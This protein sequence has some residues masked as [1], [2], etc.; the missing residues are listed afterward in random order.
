MR[1]Y[2]I[3]HSGLPNASFSYVP[4][5]RLHCAFLQYVI[6]YF[7]TLGTL[8]AVSWFL[9]LLLA[10]Q[11]HSDVLAIFVSGLFVAAC[12]KFFLFGSDV[13]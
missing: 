7:L 1:H 9:Y 12:S 6:Q 13:R 10:Q 3:E 8:G 11:F 2:S 4:I 5:S